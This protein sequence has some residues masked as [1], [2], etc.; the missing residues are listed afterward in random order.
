VRS[1]VLG[2]EP[3]RWALDGEAVAAL[4]ASRKARVI[5]RHGR[6]IRRQCPGAAI[7]IAAVGCGPLGMAFSTANLAGPG[8]GI[9]HA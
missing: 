4:R 8:E 1:Q 9:R 5:D 6:R 3:Q 7:A 2:R